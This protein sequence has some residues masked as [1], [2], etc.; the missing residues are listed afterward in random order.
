M[1]DVTSVSVRRTFFELHCLVAYD[2]ANEIDQRA[3]IV[4]VRPAHF[5]FAFSPSFISRRVASER[6]GRSCVRRLCFRSR[7]SLAV[8]R[9]ATSTAFG[10]S[11]PG[12]LPTV[13]EA[14]LGL[15][16]VIS[17]SP[18]AQL[19]ARH[20]QLSGVCGS[21]GT[22]DRL[23]LS[24]IVCLDVRGWRALRSASSATCCSA[25]L[26]SMLIA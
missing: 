22:P 23:W 24:A 4:V 15:S 13:S 3:F 2:A 25:D 6:R 26:F 1:N 20:A 10:G 18:S 11:G 17:P 16:S 12:S 7:S 14:S 9:K 5:P 8:T 19:R 21:P